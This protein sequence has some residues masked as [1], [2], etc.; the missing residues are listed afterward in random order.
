LNLLNQAKLD[1][2]IY[3]ISP[4][5]LIHP[6]INPPIIET[7]ITTT[8]YETTELFNKTE[9][10]PILFRGRTILSTVIEPTSQVRTKTEVFTT[11]IQVSPSQGPTPIVSA[12]E[13]PLPRQA[14]L[15]NLLDQARKRALATQ[16]PLQQESARL[17]NFQ[18]FQNLLNKLQ[19]KTS[20][21]LQDRTPE[22]ESAQQDVVVEEV[23][24]AQ[25]TIITK[26]VSG[27]V[28]GQYSTQL[29]TIV[30]QRRKRDALNQNDIFISSKLI[31]PT[32]VIGF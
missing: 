22:I 21:V 17:N 19:R 12:V 24:Q 9:E 8:S 26:Y 13:T 3:Q 31:R 29:E 5:P 6:S 32:R 15:Q 7:T 2:Q 23:A 4:T 14:N 27:S 1:P 16:N 30:T 20:P 11:T 25:T 28:P 18:S 10:I